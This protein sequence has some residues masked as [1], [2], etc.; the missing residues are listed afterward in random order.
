[1]QLIAESEEHG[2]QW[3]HKAKYRLNIRETAFGPMMVWSLP[4]D[5]WV[6]EEWQSITRGT[7]TMTDAQ[8]INEI[9]LGAPTLVLLFKLTQRKRGPLSTRDLEWCNRFNL[10]IVMAKGNGDNI[11]IETSINGLRKWIQA[12]GDHDPIVIVDRQIYHG[13]MKNEIRVIC[14]NRLILAPMNEWR[15]G[16]L[17]DRVL[18]YNMD[19]ELELE[20]DND[21][22]EQEMRKH[23]DRY[24]PWLVTEHA[25][26]IKRSPPSFEVGEWCKARMK[27]EKRRG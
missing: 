5:D 7:F 6:I 22:I 17:F 23:T 9:A 3:E 19:N 16:P 13:K 4:K 27:R 8:V 15:E 25:D 26:L 12:N 2:L 18:D 14:K 20:P 24:R 11:E 1:V 10:E 21:E